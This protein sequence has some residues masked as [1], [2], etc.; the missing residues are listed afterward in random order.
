MYIDLEIITIH[1][2]QQLSVVFVFVFFFSKFKVF[3]NTMLK[4]K[5]T[6]VE[7]IF[8]IVFFAIISILGTYTGFPVKNAIANT[9]AI[10]IIV[11]GLISGPIVGIGVGILAGMHRY[12]L[13][14]LTVKA[15]LFSAILQGYLAGKFHQKIGYRKT[16][17]SDG[18]VIGSLLEIFHMFI[19]IM[20]TRPVNEAIKLVKLIGPPMIIINSIGVVFFIAILDN[21]Y[22]E[23]EK[24]Q[25]KAAELVLKIANKTLP[26]LRKG[27]NSVSAKK[28]AEII[29]RMV[30][31]F[32]VVCITSDKKI[33]VSIGSEE[34]NMF[35]KTGDCIISKSIKKTLKTGKIT[36]LPKKNQVESLKEKS[37]VTT[38][39]IVPLKENE[40]VVGTIILYK[41]KENSITPFEIKLAEVLSQLISTQLE[42]SK[43]QYQSQLLAQAEIKALQ[44]QI[45]PH[46]LFNALN[47]IVYYCIKEPGKAKDLIIY[48]GE[49]Y[50]NNLV[51]LNKMVDLETEIRHVSA[52][53]QIEMARFKG[54]L[55][56]KYN[57][58]P[59]CK[60]LLPPLILQPIVENSIK[61]GILPNKEGGT[62]TISGIREN[63]NIILTVED[64]GVGMDKEIIENIFKNNKKRKNIGL[65]NVY[66]RLKSIYGNSCVFNI[67]STVGKGTK[68]TIK[69]S[70][71]KKGE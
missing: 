51:D 44:A 71:I 49:F 5:T 38:K 26:Y 31:N 70:T 61:H 22:N 17:W 8:L 37:Y 3:K 57:I 58:K 21:I 40:K 67:E 30:G 33:L 18:L 56:I 42:I 69:I 14:G 41:L 68:V 11:S 7:K 60:C 55:N 2:F 35:P 52:Y 32:D 6:I 39:V 36:L 13:G 53:V 12:F 47:T 48:L 66:D 9:R 63:E 10:G 46:F 4:K 64:D 27:L 20:M 45:N 59:D 34:N 19:V 50:R 29:Y 43:V 15:A 16:K 54:K 23:Q 1:L 65:R 24:I 28:A 62:V 25:A